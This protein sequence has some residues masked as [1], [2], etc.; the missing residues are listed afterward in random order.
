MDSRSAVAAL[1][2]H[3]ADLRARD[4]FYRTPLHFAAMFC[5]VETARLLLRH[6]APTAA[7]DG[8]EWTPLHWSIYGGSPA[9]A[10]LLVLHGADPEAVDNRGRTPRSL[11][12]STPEL[13]D[14]LQ[15]P[16]PPGGARGL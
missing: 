12:G 7:K 8:W 4:H 14:A 9:L 16:G 6:G 10:R 11:A 3:R 2:K 13:L 1:L 15:N 5:H